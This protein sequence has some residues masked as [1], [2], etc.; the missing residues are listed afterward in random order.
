M[1]VFELQMKSL[2]YNFKSVEISK[3]D[4]NQSLAQW[5][6]WVPESFENK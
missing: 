5:D 4:L 1:S 2:M 6:H 3:M